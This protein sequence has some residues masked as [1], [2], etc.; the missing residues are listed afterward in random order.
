M[1]INL[2]HSLLIPFPLKVLRHTICYN[3]NKV[4]FF[5]PPECKQQWSSFVFKDYI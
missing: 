4:I 3:Y 1:I 2:L 5:A